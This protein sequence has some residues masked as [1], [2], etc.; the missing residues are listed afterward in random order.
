MPNV[1][2]NRGEGGR[3]KDGRDRQR[4]GFMLRELAE[5]RVEGDEHYEPRGRRVTGRVEVGRG[6]LGNELGWA[7]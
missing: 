6:W 3:A 5:Q 7:S 4:D 2:A 1:V